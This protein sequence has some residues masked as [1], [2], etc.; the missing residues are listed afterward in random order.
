M[1]DVVCLTSRPDNPLTECYI[2]EWAHL[3]DLSAKFKNYCIANG[4]DELVGND[5]TTVFFPSISLTQVTF[6]DLKEDQFNVMI[7]WFKNKQEVVINS[8]G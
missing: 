1:R 7:K 4:T 6:I 5:T 8:E 3:Q 2:D